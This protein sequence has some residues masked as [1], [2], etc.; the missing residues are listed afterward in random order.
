M[1][2]E[3]SFRYVTKN[4]GE[5]RPREAAAATAMAHGIAASPQSPLPP[6]VR[7][8]CASSEVDMRARVITL[9]FEP[10]L[11]AFDD[12]P[13][14]EF[15]KGKQV[16]RIRD[17]FFANE[18]TPYLA[19][20][21]AY[22]DVAI[23]SSAA[24]I[25]KSKGS[26][27]AAWRELLADSD[28]P[29]FNALRNWRAERAKREGVPAYLICTNAQLAQMVK[30]RPRSLSGLGAIKGVGKAKLER[31]GP[32]LLALLSNASERSDSPNPDTDPAIDSGAPVPLPNS[33]EA[34]SAAG[35]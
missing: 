34:G 30:A 7:R 29:L 33:S 21:I 16:Y 23:A 10:L 14:Q 31:Y 11:G 25:E 9:R 27:R 4:P 5:R 6:A 2:Y 12:S 19:M 17:Y 26:K 18:E 28:L 20:V 24:T 35:S 13:L 32:D 22:A 8:Y 15:L 3:L 1:L